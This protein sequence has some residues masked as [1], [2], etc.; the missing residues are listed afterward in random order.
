MPFHEILN[1]VIHFRQLRHL[2]EDMPC[3]HLWAVPINFNTVRSCDCCALGRCCGAASAHRGTRLAVD[4]QT[5]FDLC[6][7]EA[8][9]GNASC[10]GEHKR[11]VDVVVRSVE[12][13]ADVIVAVGPLGF[14]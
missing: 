7:S 11:K 6:W 14:R 12:R 5:N 3:T 10:E 2:Q 9:R 1:N 4:T 8:G 13:K